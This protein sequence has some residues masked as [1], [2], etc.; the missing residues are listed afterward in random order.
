LIAVAAV[1]LVRKFSHR[2]LECVPSEDPNAELL[3]L[4]QD[5]RGYEMAEDFHSLVFN[6][7]ETRIDDNSDDFSHSGD[8]LL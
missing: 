1:L 8:E 5:E 6:N 7:E 2:E 3:C 4:P